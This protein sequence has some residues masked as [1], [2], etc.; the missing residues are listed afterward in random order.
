MSEVWKPI[1]DWESRYQVSDL[2]RIRS[3]IWNPPLILKVGKTRGYHMVILQK[4]TKG[5]SLV[6]R[7][8]TVHRLVLETFTGMR[9]KGHSLHA[10]HKDGNKDN[11]RLDNLH[12]VTVSANHLEKRAHGTM[13]RGEKSPHAKIK[14][15]DA[16]TIKR[17]LAAGDKP[18]DI[19]KDYPQVTP[20]LIYDIRRGKCWAH[21][22]SSNTGDAK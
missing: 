3:M 19:A 10:A 6:K 1:A 4:G 20:T 8:V 7:T 11:N 5:K 9:P 21:L 22:E 13:L 14:E 17:R 2:G 12:W 15:I 18:M 16:I